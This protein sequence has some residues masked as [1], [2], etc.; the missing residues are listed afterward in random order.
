MTAHQA[1]KRLEAIAS[2][3]AQM[4][5]E[6]RR[7]REAGN[8][9]RSRYRALLDERDRLELHQHIGKPVRMKY[10]SGGK[11]DRA[12]GTLQVVRRTRVLVDFGPEYGG[13]WNVPLSALQPADE[14]HTQGYTLRFAE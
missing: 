7:P 11:F 4:Q 5:E 14:H 9:L 12:I 6:D 2:K 3:L 8:T 10:R 13:E 1:T